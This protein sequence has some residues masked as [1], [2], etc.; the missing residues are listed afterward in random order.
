MEYI[1]FKKEKQKEFLEVI[2]TKTGLKWIE[3]A[4]LLNISKS[5]VN[6]LYKENCSMRESIFQELCNLI[7]VN[8]TAFDEHISEKRPINNSNIKI[9]EFISPELAELIGIYL[10]DGHINQNGLII[11][12]GKIDLRY[13]TKYIPNLIKFLFDKTSSIYYFKKSNGVQCRVYSRDIVNYIQKQFNLKLGKKKNSSIPEMILHESTLLIPCIR[14]LF[15]T[16]GGLYRHHKTNLQI[17]FFNSQI[18][19][20]DSLKKALEHLG[21][22]PRI[23]KNNDNYCLYLFGKEAVEYYNKIGFSNFKNNLKF[24]IWSKHG[25]IP[26]NKLIKNIC[27]RRGSNPGHDVFA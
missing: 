20:I 3:L 2:R 7:N 22:N 17:I 10:G 23:G 4:G 11:T 9:P 24:K 5:M 15:D 18:S 6:H 25:R 19:L 21:Y 1:I 26:T 12:C 8:P 27:E 16:D 13:I 14:G